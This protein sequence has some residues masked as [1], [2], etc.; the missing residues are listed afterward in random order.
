M[1]RNRLQ[2]DRGDVVND[3]VRYNN[4]M[5]RARARAPL[6]WERGLIGRSIFRVTAETINVRVQSSSFMDHFD[7]SLL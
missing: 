5:A 2:R 6:L 1:Y 7:V 4:R 3:V